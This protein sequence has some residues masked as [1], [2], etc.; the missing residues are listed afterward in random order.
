MNRR[1]FLH[2]LLVSSAAV[3]ATER[4]YSFLRNNPLAPERLPYFGIDRTDFPVRLSGHKLFIPR[5][6][7]VFLSGPPRDQMIYFSKVALSP[8]WV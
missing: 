4:V 8:S 2:S 7:R 6:S 5:D 1:G 3:V